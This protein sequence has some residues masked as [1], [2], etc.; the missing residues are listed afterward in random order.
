[1]TE[2]R[3]ST[4]AVE[5]IGEKPHCPFCGSGRVYFRIKQNNFLCQTCSETFEKDDLKKV[6][7]R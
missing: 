5:T 3:G 1:M 6:G 4:Q 2:V 7:G